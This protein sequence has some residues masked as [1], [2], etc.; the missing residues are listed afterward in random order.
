MTI[1]KKD[2]GTEGKVETK[3]E[4]RWELWEEDL[5]KILLDY[6]SF[7]GEFTSDEESLTIESKF[8]KSGW[9]IETL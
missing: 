4:I 3:R 6:L 7:S 1:R 9:Y 5:K 2:R 8:S